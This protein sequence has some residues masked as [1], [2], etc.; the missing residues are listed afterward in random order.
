[1]KN[2]RLLFLL[3]G[4]NFCSCNFIN[5]RNNKL[6][7]DSLHKVSLDTISQTLY[8]LDSNNNKINLPD[9][10]SENSQYSPERDYNRFFKTALKG[11]YHVKY[12]RD[13]QYQ[14][15]VLKKDAKILDTI[16]DADIGESRLKA[17][18]YVG[19]DFN[20]YF[21]FVNSFGSGN[22]NYI[23]LIEKKTGKNVIEKGSS[24]IDANEKKEVLLYANEGWNKMTLYDIKY[25]SKKI[26]PLPSDL[27]SF[28]ERLKNIELV[29]VTKKYFKIAYGTETAKKKKT[30]NR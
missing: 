18:G 26:F 6:H 30:Y 20:N 8:V 25:K 27:P 13:S 17:L 21:V 9:T 3:V 15:I 2:I 23:K 11:G 24:W 1:M 7:K 28:P 10:N 16:N 14:Y 5:D 22:P 12:L 4:I 19:A 29:V